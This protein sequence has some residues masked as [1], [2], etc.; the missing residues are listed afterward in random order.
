MWSVHDDAPVALLHVG[1]DGSVTAVNRAWCELTDLAS[2]GSCGTG[3]LAVLDSAARTTMLA[4]IRGATG[5]TRQVDTVLELGARRLP[6]RWSVRASRDGSGVVMAV[7]NA[8][9][10]RPATYRRDTGVYPPALPADATTRLVLDLY[11]VSL[12]LAP[13]I[14]LVDDPVADRL[15][16]AIEQLDRAICRVRLALLDHERTTPTEAPQVVRAGGGAGG[17]HR[18]AEASAPPERSP[19]SQVPSP[20]HG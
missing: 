19:I 4:A 13:C 6:T 10:G 16:R 18:R 1:V 7:V 11:A 9:T 15:A 14:R 20:R 12:S 2:E 8:D 3:W 5:D 17:P